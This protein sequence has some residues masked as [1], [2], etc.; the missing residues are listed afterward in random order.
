MLMPALAALIAAG[1]A[2]KA[3]WQSHVLK[4]VPKGKT[5]SQP[6]KTAWQRYTLEALAEPSTKCQASKTVW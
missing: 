4:A 2:L 1:Q 5:K 6:L 3:A